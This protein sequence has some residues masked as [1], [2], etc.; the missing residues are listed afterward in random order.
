MFTAALFPMAETWTQSE[1]PST[2]GW[3]KTV[4]HIQAMESYSGFQKKKEI[5]IYG[6]R[7]TYED[8]MN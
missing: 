3:I 7:L 2:D 4:W 1:C 8:V 6:V 5:L